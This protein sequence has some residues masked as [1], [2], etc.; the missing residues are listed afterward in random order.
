MRRLKNLLWILLALLLAAMSALLLIDNPTPVSLRFLNFATP[1][2]PVFWW[3]LATLI[4]GIAVGF[5]LCFVGFVR[6]KVTER[7]LR[8]ELDQNKQELHRI[9]TMS[10]HD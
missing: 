4:I 8:R 9:R 5:A 2:V 1:P 10:L 3:L 6:G 7:Q